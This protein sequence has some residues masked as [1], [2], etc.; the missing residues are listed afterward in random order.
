MAVKIA[1]RKTWTETCCKNFPK[2]WRYHTPNCCQVLTQ[3]V[4]LHVRLLIA[5]S[6]YV[7]VMYVIYFIMMK[8]TCY[9]KTSIP[10]KCKLC[11][12]WP[13]LQSVGFV[14]SFVVVHSFIYIFFNFYFGEWNGPVSESNLINN[15]LYKQLFVLFGFE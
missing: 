12:C 13:F 15:M 6:L 11:I 9:E 3:V 4:E 14:F 1:T 8:P 5:V 10:V 7:M 2:Q